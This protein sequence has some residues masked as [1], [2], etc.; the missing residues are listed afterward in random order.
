MKVLIGVDV[1][2]LNG[3]TVVDPMGGDGKHSIDFRNLDSICD[4]SECEEIRAPHILGHIHGSELMGTLNNW[5]S[6]LRHG[7]KIIVGGYDI[8]ECS[9]AVILGQ[10]SVSDANKMFYNTKDSPWNVNFGMYEC[11]EIVGILQEFGLKVDKKRVNGSFF[12]VEAHRE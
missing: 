8:F 2:P 12:V 5:I 1:A 9:K 3:Y 4:V 11:N 10:M 6:K 7:G